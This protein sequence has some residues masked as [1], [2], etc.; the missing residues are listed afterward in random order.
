MIE[1]HFLA[2]AAAVSFIAL[3]ILPA[4]VRAESLPFQ[5]GYYLPAAMAQFCKGGVYLKSDQTV[6]FDKKRGTYGDVDGV[7]DARSIRPSSG[8]YTV[9]WSCDSMG[10]IS[11]Q[12]TKITTKGASGKV[13][14]IDG[15]PYV[16]CGP[17]Q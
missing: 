7:C 13:T 5:G 6:S 8:G 9:K 15:D 12:T 11:Q 3:A 16:Y 17:V 1:R 2:I 4:T 14:A 10:E